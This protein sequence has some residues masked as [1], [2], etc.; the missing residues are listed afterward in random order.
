MAMG[1]RIQERPWP[2]IKQLRHAVSGDDAHVQAPA[3]NDGTL[4]QLPLL[5]PQASGDF[6]EAA[7]DAQSFRGQRRVGR[8]Q[9]LGVLQERTSGVRVRSW[10]M[11][12]ASA[13]LALSMTAAST[14]RGRC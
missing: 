9:A 12:S 13:G 1:A 5:Q 10:T 4:L 3:L 7:G 6:K 11:R 14:S 2:L 8:Q